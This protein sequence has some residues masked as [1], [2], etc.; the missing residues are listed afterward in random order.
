MTRFTLNITAEDLLDLLKK[1][2]A[3]YS[4]KLDNAVIESDFQEAKILMN[5]LEELAV[6]LDTTPVACSEASLTIDLELS[7]IPDPS[8]PRG[9]L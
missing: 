1:Q 5:K 4:V 2:R 6:V 3:R 8:L 7:E 9:M